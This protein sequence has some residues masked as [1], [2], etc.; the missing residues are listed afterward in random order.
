MGPRL[1]E[2]GE[3]SPLS[4][5]LAALLADSGP[6]VACRLLFL[7]R[8]ALKYPGCSGSAT[9]LAQTPT[10]T[11]VVAWWCWCVSH[12]LVD[13]DCDAKN[14]D[15]AIDDSEISID[16]S[17]VDWKVD[18]GARKRR[19]DNDWVMKILFSFGW[20]QVYFTESNWEPRIKQF[21]RPVQAHDF[22][23][24]YVIYKYTAY[25]HFVIDIITK[26]SGL[27]KQVFMPTQRWKWT[28]L[29]SF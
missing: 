21:L 19:L 25:N 12:D 22:Q 18:V 24:R 1:G 3:I 7:F 9:V 4:P 29:N 13:V 6:G 14:F 10:S 23:G 17:E 5:L 27:I 26:Q 8:F 28:G 11:P 16:S 2:G 15:I 20:F